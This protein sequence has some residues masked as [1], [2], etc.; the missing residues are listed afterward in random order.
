MAQNIIIYTVVGRKLTLNNGIVK[1]RPEQAKTRLHNLEPV[2]GFGKNGQYKIKKPIEFKRGEEL[3][4]DVD[5]VGRLSK[6]NAIPKETMENAVRDAVD[7][8]AGAKKTKGMGVAKELADDDP[9][10]DGALS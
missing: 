8:A 9:T 1:L 3:G 2:G 10:A 7:K 6:Q 4:I 5:T